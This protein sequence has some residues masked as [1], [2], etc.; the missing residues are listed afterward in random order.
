MNKI[1]KTADTFIEIVETGT[2]DEV[3][4]L[5]KAGIPIMIRNSTNINGLHA[6]IM[7]EKFKTAEWFWDNGVTEVSGWEPW[8]KIG[9]EKYM[10]YFIKF[11]GIYKWPAVG[12]TEA[13]IRG[14]YK[15]VEWAIKNVTSENTNQVLAVETAKANSIAI[16]LTNGT[17][18]FKMIKLCLDSIKDPTL[19]DNVIML[20]AARNKNKINSETYAY[21]MNN[22]KLIENAV[23]LKQF[24]LL[25]K[26]ITDVF[27]F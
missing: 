22:P 7:A 2:L 10:K 4:K 20:Q 9:C 19:N 8:Y 24:D 18:S 6:A 14:E 17:V 12:L 3:K 21:I 13:I 15:F 16:T 11:D 26:E 23:K 5:V 1:N 25:P 27:I